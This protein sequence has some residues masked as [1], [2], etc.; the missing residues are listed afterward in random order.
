MPLLRKS[1]SKLC[2]LQFTFQFILTEKLEFLMHVFYSDGEGQYTCAE[3]CLVFFR[4][5][6]SYHDVH[7]MTSGNTSLE[8]AQIM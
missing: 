7:A 4:P 2:K 5:E 6:G 1:L 8:E 3:V